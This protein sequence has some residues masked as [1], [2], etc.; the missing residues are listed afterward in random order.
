[1][2]TETMNMYTVSI[3][4]N[5][6]DAPMKRKIAAMSFKQAT[7]MAETFTLGGKL[8]II[9]IEYLEPIRVPERWEIKS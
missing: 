3:K 7:E 8:Q 4:V 1:M 2:N 9:R 6:T 5:D